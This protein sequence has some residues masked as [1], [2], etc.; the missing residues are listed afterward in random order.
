MKTANNNTDAIGLPAS[1][2]GTNP[3]ICQCNDIVFVTIV[4]VICHISSVIVDNV[5][6]LVTKPV[7][8]AFSFACAYFETQHH[9]AVEYM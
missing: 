1:Q 9:V 2:A 7:P 5:S 3:Q 8:V 6:S 4:A